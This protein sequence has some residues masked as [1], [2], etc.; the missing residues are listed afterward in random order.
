MKFWTAHIRQGHPP[1]LVRESFAYGAL[2][3]GPFWLA[4]QR[5]WVPAALSLA[6]GVLVVAL[7]PAGTAAVIMLAL[8]VWLGLS[9]HDLV[10]WSIEHR[11]FTLAQV[12]AAT[13]E[14]EALSV[15][16]A[17]RPDLAGSFLPP[18]A[19]R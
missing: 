10:R 17:R 1:V 11:G 5:A 4:A 13:G 7:V 15:F 19:A 14:S 3:L 6:A 2:F 18:Q 8:A 16:L 9:G 12:I